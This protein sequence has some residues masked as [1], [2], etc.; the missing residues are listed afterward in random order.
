MILQLFG[1]EIMDLDNYIKSLPDKSLSKVKILIIS[2]LWGNG[3]KFPTDWVSSSYLLKLTKQ[4]YFDRRVR[5]L[6]DQ[7]GC[8]IET[9]H[10]HGEHQYR[11]ISQ[12]LN[13]ANPRL[14]L[15]N[16]QKKKLF[17]SDNYTCQICDRKI[18][19]GIRGLQ[20]DHKV[21][22]SRGGGHE[23]DNWQSL[24]NECNVM[25]RRSCADCDLD[26]LSCSWAFPTEN[27]IP[28]TLRL[29][30]DIY[31]NIKKINTDISAYL[32]DLIKKHT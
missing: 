16:T 14:Y 5:E 9:M 27:G 23:Q 13:K 26:C 10:V 7:S 24:C 4:K 32:V 25:K 3:I 22:L 20:A 18:E 8:D 6:R 31:R 21:P 1:C 30:A 19:P 15:T 17:Q 11:L 28:I 2:T 12:K 29:D